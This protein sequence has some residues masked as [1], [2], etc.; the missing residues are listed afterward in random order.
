[1]KN[2]KIYRIWIQI[3]TRCFN[4]NNHGYKHYGARGITLS[5][6]WI[7]DYQNFQEYV[8]GLPNFDENNIGRGGITL[9][10]YDNNGNYEKG[11]LRWVTMEIQNRNR[12]KKSGNLS[13]IYTGISYDN[14]GLRKKRWRVRIS[15]N[16]KI[17][18]I[19]RFE[20]EL[21]AKEARNKYIIENKLEGFIIN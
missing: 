20:T 19:G 7:N 4:K 15:V 2:R 21:Q 3:K 9:D 13:S 10:R 16:K 6:E 17:I 18:V 8:I 1:M 14:S 11:N 12:R 5:P